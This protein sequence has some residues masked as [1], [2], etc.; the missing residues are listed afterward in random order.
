MYLYIYICVVSYFSIWACFWIA[1][2][3]THFRKVERLGKPNTQSKFDS[4]CVDFV[5]HANEL[6]VDYYDRHSAIYTY[7]S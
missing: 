5:T 4:F 7:C 6:S 1:P 2:K 3:K